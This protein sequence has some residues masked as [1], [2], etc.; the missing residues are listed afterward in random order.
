MLMILKGNPVSGGY[1]VG[2]A[3]LYKPYE[4]RVTPGTIE[5]AQA[6]AALAA[7]GTAKEEAARELDAVI[8]SMHAAGDAD[9]AKIFEAHKEILF[10]EEI[11]MMVSESIAE[12]LSTPDCAVAETFQ[13]LIELLGNTGNALIAARAADLHDVCM[14]V[15]RNLHGEKERNLSSLPEEVIVVAHD[16]LPSDTATLD[17]KNV[18]GIVTEIGSGTSH[19]AI[20]ARSFQIPAVLGVA[21]AMEKIGDGEALTLDAVR[22]EIETGPTAEQ[23]DRFCEKRAEYLRKHA[24]EEAYRGKPA[25]TTDGVRVEIGL[26]VGDAAFA[27]EYQ[28]SD[29]VGLFRTEFLYMRSESMPTEEQQFQAYRQVLCNAGGKPVTLRTLDIGGDKTLPYLTLPHEENPF[30]GER[31]LRLCLKHRDLFVTQLRAA[32]RASAYG[33]LWLM[34]PMVGSIDDILRAK[35][36]VNEVKEQLRAENTP[37]DEAVK[38]GVMIEIP[39]IALIADLAAQ[40]VDFASVGTNDLCQYV[41]AADRMNSE[42]SGYYQTLSPAMLRILQDIARAFGAAG[43]PVSVC[44]EMAGA[45]DAATVLV[46]LGFRKLSM[47][48]GNMAAVKKR[49]CEISAAAAEEAARAGQTL[50]TQRDVRA[51]LQ[52]LHPGNRETK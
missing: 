25:V 39:S 31:A 49:I 22:G 48:A 7:W 2:K 47:S 43:K 6:P 5:K 14:R 27:P 20:I 33:E 38:L 19:S 34:F 46:G 1:A 12:S 11:E 30:L 23:S 51:L 9:Q 18:L 37:F 32:L 41:C 26:N 50:R 21:D 36:L 16:L 8:A 24:E 3:F 10:D 44:G 40:E 52:N 13:T 29:F 4:A 35:E 45:P 28:D 17:R 42:I 15:I